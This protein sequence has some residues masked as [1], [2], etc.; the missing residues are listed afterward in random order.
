VNRIPD[1]T[2]VAC[3]FYQGVEGFDEMTNCRK[4]SVEKLKDRFHLGGVR[5]TRK[6]GV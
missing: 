3:G 2:G 6:T 5:I 1:Q 4:P